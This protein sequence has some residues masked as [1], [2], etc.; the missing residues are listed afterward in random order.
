MSPIP[1][2]FLSV[3]WTSGHVVW[4]T[5]VLLCVCVCVC[6]CVNHS[7]VTRIRAGHYNVQIPAGLRGFYH[8]PELSAARMWGPPSPLFSG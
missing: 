7:L 6:V 2:S 8:S 1:W 5:E 4:I 3:V